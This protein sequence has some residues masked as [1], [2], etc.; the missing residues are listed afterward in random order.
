[1]QR[2]VPIACAAAFAAGLAACGEPYVPA[3]QAANP[4]GAVSPEKSAK[5]VAEFHSSIAPASPPAEAKLADTDLSN[6]VRQTLTSTAGMEIGG[7]EVAAADGVVTIYGTVEGP[8]EKNRAAMLAMSIDGVRS[9]VNN[10][11]VIRSS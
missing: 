5:P 8:Q 10:L 6:R 4:G 2:L 9:V 11:V 1:M 7:V 3:E